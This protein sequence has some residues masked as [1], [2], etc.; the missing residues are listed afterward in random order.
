VK[1]RFF[2]DRINAFRDNFPI[3]ESI[4]LAIDILPHGAK[5]ELFRQNKTPL[6]A[7]GAM[8]PFIF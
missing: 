1:K 8:Y 2:F 4:E 7:G 5:S 6:G 3:I